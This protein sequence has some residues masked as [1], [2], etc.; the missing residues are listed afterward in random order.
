MMMII[1][2]DDNDDDDDDYQGEERADQV[3]GGQCGVPRRRLLLHQQSGRWVQL[4]GV[5]YYTL[6]YQCMCE[7]LGASTG[8]PPRMRQYWT[9]THRPSTRMSVLPSSSPRI[10][11]APP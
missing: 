3:Q 7:Q 10:P 2:D 1:D 9:T 5:H 8:P 6:R 4:M 11:S